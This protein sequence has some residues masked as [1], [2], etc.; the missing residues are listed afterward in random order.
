MDAKEE[1]APSFSFTVN[2]ESTG[3]MKGSEH[4]KN[5][6]YI[7]ACCSSKANQLQKLEDYFTQNTIF[8]EVYRY[9][10]IRG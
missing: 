1:K 10:C 2:K 9:K 3:T 6:T 4:Y 7:P 8:Q 5:D